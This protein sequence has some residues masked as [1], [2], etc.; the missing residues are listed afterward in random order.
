MLSNMPRSIARWLS[1]RSVSCI[2][3]MIL[4]LFVLVCSRLMLVR[5]VRCSFVLNVFVVLGLLDSSARIFFVV[6]R[7]LVVWMLVWVCGELVSVVKCIWL[8]VVSDRLG[9]VFY[10]WLRNFYL[11]GL[12]LLWSRRKWL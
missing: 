6:V 2:L 8:M 3:C 12:W 4:M 9:L 5:W 1:S 11:L 10:M 7:C